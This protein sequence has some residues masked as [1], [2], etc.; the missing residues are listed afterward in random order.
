M[1]SNETGNIYKIFSQDWQESNRKD[2]THKTIPCELGRMIKI[3]SSSGRHSPP[4]LATNFVRDHGKAGP[5][6]CLGIEPFPG[7]RLLMDETGDWDLTTFE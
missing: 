3:F 6:V 4:I 7:G 5:G 1:F 2:A